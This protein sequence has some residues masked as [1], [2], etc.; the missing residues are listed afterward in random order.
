M[1]LKI[2]FKKNINSLDVCEITVLEE[3]RYCPESGPLLLIEFN[4][5]I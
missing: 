4:N 2:S 5:H 1:S 3:L